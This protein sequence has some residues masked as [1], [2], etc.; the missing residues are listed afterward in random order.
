[1]TITTE[2]A[3]PLVAAARDLFPRLDA[4]WEETESGRRVPTHLV[5]EMRRAG[6]FRMVVP[7]E[8]GGARVDLRT[9][10][11]VLE[12]VAR[13]NSA[14]AWDLAASSMC[15]LFALGLPPQ[16]LERVYANGPDVIFAGTVT[17]T[18]TPPSAVACGGRVSGDRTLALRQR[19]PGRRLG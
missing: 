16:G 7:T 13:G 5:E 6:L 12:T 3:P 19:L 14:A 1:M 2:A 9:F 15:T 10:V 8:F 18:E 11:E 4:A 17:S